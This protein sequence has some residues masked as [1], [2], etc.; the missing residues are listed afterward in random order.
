MRISSGH[1]RVVQLVALIALAAPAAAQVHVWKD[2]DGQTHYSDIPPRGIDSQ[3][4]DIPTPSSQGGN[5]GAGH[6]TLQEQEAEFRKRQAERSEAE[7]KQADESAR[8]AKLARQCAD[9]R[10]QLKALESGQRV[11]RFNAKGEREYL[12]DAQREEAAAD[13]RKSLE[14]HCSQ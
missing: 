14:E 1:L 4:V 11:T 10:N 3:T 12:N 8:K 9:A 6:K 5:S 13:L 2:S 7:A